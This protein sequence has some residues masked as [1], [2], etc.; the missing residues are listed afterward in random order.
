VTTPSTTN[1]TTCPARQALDKAAADLRNAGSE[2]L[3]AERAMSA[4]KVELR[5]SNMKA[6]DDR[7]SMFAAFHAFATLSNELRR[8]KFEVE[9]YDCEHERALRERNAAGDELD[10]AARV[11]GTGKMHSED[12]L[13]RAAVRFAAAQHVLDLLQ[14]QEAKAKRRK[15][16]LELRQA[17][18]SIDELERLYKQSD[19]IEKSSRASAQVVEAEWN[20]LR[21]EWLKAMKAE[22]ECKKALRLASLVYTASVIRE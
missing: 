19:D 17:E 11:Q 13:A 4:K 16:V 14:S 1:D 18:A 21:N 12:E 10:R 8:L 9:S 7:D 2:I 15:D 22:D 3:K 20:V 6:Q 5:L